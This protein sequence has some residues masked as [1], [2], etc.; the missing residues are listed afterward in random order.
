M[1][2][3]TGEMMDMI[4]VDGTASGLYTE[5]VG[6]STLRVGM[7][8]KREEEGLISISSGDG[9]L[10]MNKYFFGATWLIDSS[11]DDV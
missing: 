9:I 5:K 7:R 11:Q 3:T 4:Q 10:R 1:G 2:L 8:I 6:T